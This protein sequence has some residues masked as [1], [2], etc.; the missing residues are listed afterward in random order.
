MDLAKK[1]FSLRYI[2]SATTTLGYSKYLNCCVGK[3]REREKSVKQ[4]DMQDD[5]NRAFKSFTY[6]PPLTRVLIIF[7]NPLS[8]QCGY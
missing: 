3:R 2:D 1:D 7:T 6:N 8:A 5:R 4:L